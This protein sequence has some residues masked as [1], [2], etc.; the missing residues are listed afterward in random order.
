MGIH[1]RTHPRYAIPQNEI[2]ISC[3]DKDCDRPSSEALMVFITEKS[4]AKLM[5]FRFFA[6]E[7]YSFSD[8]Q[9]ILLPNGAWNFWK[10]LS[11]HPGFGNKVKIAIRRKWLSNKKK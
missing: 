7:Y 11:A 9:L 6:L 5:V 3:L 10:V 4:L 2:N 8:Y 1:R